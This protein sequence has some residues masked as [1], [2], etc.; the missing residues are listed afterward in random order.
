MMSSTTGDA[1]SGAKDNRVASGMMHGAA[2][3]DRLIESRKALGQGRF[4]LLDQ[5]EVRTDGT[6][7]QAPRAAHRPSPPAAGEASLIAVV[8]G[9]ADPGGAALLVAWLV[10]GHRGIKVAPRLTTCQSAPSSPASGLDL[11]AVERAGQRQR[12]NRLPWSAS[13]LNSQRVPSG[14]HRQLDQ[15]RG[16]PRTSPAAPT[17]PTSDT[18]GRSCEGRQKNA[19]ERRA[20]V[21]HRATTITHRPV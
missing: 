5:G 16:I 15:H 8:A 13:T 18:M 14:L 10:P 6:Q 20:M 11:G 21:D 19:I 9:P 2:P 4:D 7:R 17:W 12:E 3:S 1:G